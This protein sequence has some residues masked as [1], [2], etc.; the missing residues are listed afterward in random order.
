MDILLEAALLIVWGLILQLDG[1]VV[2]EDQQH[3][4]F[5]QVFVEMEN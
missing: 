3:Q 2:V 4:A 1:F 5:V